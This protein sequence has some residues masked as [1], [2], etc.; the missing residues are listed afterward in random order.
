MRGFIS[1]VLIV[2]SFI[3]SAEEYSMSVNKKNNSFAVSLVANPTTGFEWSVIG[4][5]KQLLTLTKSSYQKPKTN[6]MG[7]G[8]QMIF[9]FTLNAGKSYP[10]NTII[11]FKYA[12]HWEPETAVL[13]KIAIYFK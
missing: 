13:K 4:Y 5:D 9:T 10:K 3:A 8:G 1:I 2:F 6:L 7:A 12:R 11:A